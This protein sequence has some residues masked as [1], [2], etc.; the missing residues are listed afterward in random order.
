MHDLGL[1][2]AAHDQSNCCF[3]LLNELPT[4]V[5]LNEHHLQIAKCEP[6]EYGGVCFVHELGLERLPRT[7]ISAVLG[8]PM[9]W[10][11]CLREMK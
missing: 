7:Y 4:F 8:L 1:K 9:E 5:L 3:T 2:Q 11:S 10:L 6:N